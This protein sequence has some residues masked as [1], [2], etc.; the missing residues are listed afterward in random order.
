[1]FLSHGKYQFGNTDLSIS[2]LLRRLHS[3]S[4]HVS[5]ISILAVSR[6]PIGIISHTFPEHLILSFISDV[7]N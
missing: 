1:M 2:H 6:A 7:C 5:A 3:D 4:V